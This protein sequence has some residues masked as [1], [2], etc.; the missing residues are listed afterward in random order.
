[1]NELIAEYKDNIPEYH[2]DGLEL[3]ILPKKFKK[4]T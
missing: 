1:M 4:Y 2:L 3:H